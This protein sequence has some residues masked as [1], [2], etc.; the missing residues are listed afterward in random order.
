VAGGRV[1]RSSRV[2]TLSLFPEVRKRLR[3][4]LAELDE[5]EW[6]R[7]MVCPGW[8]V[9]DVA[10]H[11]LG[12]E[13]S[14]LS[15][16]RDGV[17]LGPEPGRDLAEWLHAHNEAWVR[18]TRFVGN[19]TLIELLDVCGAAFEDFLATLDLDE[20]SAHVFWAGDEAVPVWLDVAR[21]YTERWVHQQQIRDACGRPGLDDGR[22]LGPVIATFVHALPH[23]YR[24]VQAPPG[25]AVELRV[26]GAGVWHVLRAADRWELVDGAHPS[27]GATVTADGDTTWRLF[28]RNPL[29]RSPA[30]DGDVA[31]GGVMLGAV[32]IVA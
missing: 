5:A 4:L 20:V 10:L 31:L 26:T 28:T 29:A 8:D 13:I 17:D 23:A 24:D 27:P 9:K 1:S 18:A 30:I 2:D 11:L 21:E 14:N 22:L 12:G 16:R 25:T 15:R 7:P 19:R 6:K 3:E 32:A